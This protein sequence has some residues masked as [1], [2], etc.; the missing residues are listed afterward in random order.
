[1][2][3]VHIEYPDHTNL[4]DRQL[5][6]IW[7]VENRLLHN[8]CDNDIERSNPIQMLIVRA[9]PSDEHVQLPAVSYRK[10]E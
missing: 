1:M 6:S 2:T 3:A 9:K 10:L 4:L 7:H 8:R 5:P